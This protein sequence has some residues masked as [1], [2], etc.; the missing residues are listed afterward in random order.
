MKKLVLETT[1][2]FQGLPE[3]VA[4]DEG[5]F[6]KEGLR[7]EWAD[8][9]KGVE[10]K[11]ELQVTSPKG[12]NPFASHGKLF[13]QGKADMYNAC[14]WGNYCRVQDTGTGSRQL[15][16]RAIVAYAALVVAPD[17]P[18]FTPQQ[19]ANK[20]IGVPFYFGTHYIA[21]HMLEGFLP[22]E[23]IK[24]CRAPNGSRYRLDALMRG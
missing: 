6:E 18:V 9:E 17:S 3:L 7:I 23:M 1:A 13:E 19:L 21:L 2:P 11:V 22:R 10:K 12:V 14:E 24:L 8:R 16:R 15:G 4:Y 20:T 5:L